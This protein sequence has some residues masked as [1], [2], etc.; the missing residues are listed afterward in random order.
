MCLIFTFRLSKWNFIT[1]EIFLQITVY[2]I[3]IY[4]YIYLDQAI[5]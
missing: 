5:T 2:I 1:N 4:I 3:Y